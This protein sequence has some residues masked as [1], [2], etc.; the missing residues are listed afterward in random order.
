MMEVKSFSESMA[1]NRER[2]QPQSSITREELSENQNR[3]FREG[4]NTEIMEEI[5]LGEQRTEVTL[6]R[7]RAGD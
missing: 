7:A 1:D 5:Q 3:V 6:K 4:G 2:S